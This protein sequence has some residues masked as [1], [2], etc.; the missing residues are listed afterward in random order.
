VTTGALAQLNGLGSTDPNGLALSYTWN[1]LS[2][3][4]GSLANITPEGLGLASF[5]A[6]FA[7]SYTV[8]LVVSDAFGDLLSHPLDSQFATVVITATTHETSQQFLQD[9]IN[10]IAATP[11]S[12]FDAPGHKNA[13][14]NQLQ[15]AIIDTQQR[16]ISQASGK[17]SDAITRTDGFPLRGRLDGDGPGMDWITNQTDQNFVYDKLTAALSMLQ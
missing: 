8:Q 17:I 15:Q 16:N 2:K 10:F 6:D 7:G 12:H 9:V 3:P 11:P 5:T 13:L 14:T 4:N 1:F